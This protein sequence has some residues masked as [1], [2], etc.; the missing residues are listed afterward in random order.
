MFDHVQEYDFVLQKG[1][2]DKLI[3]DCAFRENLQRKKHPSD[4]GGCEGF[5]PSITTNGMCYTFNGKHSSEIWTASKMMKAFQNLFPSQI[6]SNKTFGGSR[7]A[8]GND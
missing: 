8:Q 1:T 7:T 5:E 6:K 4:H 3:I 2:Y